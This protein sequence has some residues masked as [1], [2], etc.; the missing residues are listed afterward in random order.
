MVG[1]L[2]LDPEMTGVLI[3][4]CGYGLPVVLSSAPMAGSTSPVTLA[5]T[6]VQLHAEQL[7]GVVLAQIVRP[8]TPLLAG[9]I[10]G[11]ANLR[12]GEYLG[13]VMGLGRGPRQEAAA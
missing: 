5:G 11:L 8:G 3:D 9:Y 13:P 1:P 4:W 12:S 2:R 6:L 10:P 7:S